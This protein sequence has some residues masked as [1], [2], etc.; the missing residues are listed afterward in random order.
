MAEAAPTFV[1]LRCG[2]CC[3]RAGDVRLTG[4][5]TDRAASFLGMSAREFADRYTRL[6]ADRG[7]LSLVDRDG[8][9]CVFLAADDTCR[10][11]AAK[12]GQCRE[13]PTLWRDPDWQRICAGANRKPEQTNQPAG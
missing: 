9:A 11:H 13:Y 1:C 7:A 5:D 6:A 3:R 12:P 8:N 10:I 2:A 4:D